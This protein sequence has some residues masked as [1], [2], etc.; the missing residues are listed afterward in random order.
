MIYERSL[1]LCL[2][3]PS[4]VMIRRDL[5]DIVGCFDESLPACE[6]YDLWLRISCRFPVFLIDNPLII[7]R[8]GHSDQLSRA[9]GLDK[10]RIRAIEKMLKSGLLSNGQIKASLSVLK[11]KCA[12]YAAGCE[13]RNRLEEAG[14][15]REISRRYDKDQQF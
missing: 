4:A 5:F 11:E 7:K 1:E 13:K 2:V 3:S 15:Y 6:D 8:G 12:I 14:Y 9:P 10:Y